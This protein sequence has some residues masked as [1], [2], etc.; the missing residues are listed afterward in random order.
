MCIVSIIFSVLLFI[1]FFIFLFG[2][3][4]IDKTDNFII[5]CSFMFGSVFCMC[6]SVYNKEKLDYNK[7]IDYYDSML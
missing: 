2:N 4:D 7:T 3:F 6:L 5:L 1:T